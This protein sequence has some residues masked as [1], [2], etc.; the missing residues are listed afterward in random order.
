MI[1]ARKNVY[2][3]ALLIPII[4][5]NLYHQYSISA[6]SNNYPHLKSL[7]LAQ[8]SNETFLKVNILIGLDYYYNFMTGSL[9]KGKSNELIGPDSTLGWIVSRSYSSINSTNAYNIKSH[10][11]FVPPSNCRYIV[12]E[13]KADH[14]LPTIWDI[15]CVEVNSKELEIYQSFEN[16]LEFTGERYSIKLLFKTTTELVLDNCITPENVYKV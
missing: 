6:I 10:F 1:G 8:E 4:C 14:K 16:D 7:K 3:E 15:E 5:S 2:V 13:N 9:I 12:F 11:L